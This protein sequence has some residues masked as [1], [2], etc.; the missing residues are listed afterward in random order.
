MCG[1]MKIPKLTPAPGNQ[2]RGPND[3]E[4]DALSHDQGHRTHTSSCSYRNI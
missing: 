3:Y 2:T 4:A 1:L